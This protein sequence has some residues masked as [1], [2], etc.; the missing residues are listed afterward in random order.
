M[1]G[2]IGGRVEANAHLFG[3]LAGLVFLLSYYLYRYLF[4]K[5]NADK[6]YQNE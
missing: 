5:N 2:M 6:L 3:V 1:L 4:Q